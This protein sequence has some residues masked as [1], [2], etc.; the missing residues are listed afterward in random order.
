MEGSETSGTL[1]L[2]MIIQAIITIAV[3]GLIYFIVRKPIRRMVD[4][5]FR[6]NDK[7]I[8]KTEDIQNIVANKE[9]QDITSKAK[10]RICELE[11]ERTNTEEH[12]KQRAKEEEK[13]ILESFINKAHKTITE[14]RDNAIKEMRREFDEIIL[15]SKDN[16][17]LKRESRED[18]NQL[19]KSE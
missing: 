19:D 3:F 16:S 5:Y 1:Y 13:R 10:K 2:T 11:D 15:D 8:Q 17:N 14:E 7:R 9:L 18:E 4:K 6:E 12:I